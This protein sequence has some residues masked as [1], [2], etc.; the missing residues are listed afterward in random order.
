V[1]AKCDETVQLTE[2][3]VSVIIEGWA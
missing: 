1:W 2:T 3:D